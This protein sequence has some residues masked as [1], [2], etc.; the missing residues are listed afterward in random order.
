MTQNTDSPAQIDPNA[1]Q[2]DPR[3]P[4]FEDAAPV[5]RPFSGGRQAAPNP[6]AGIIAQIAL[7]TDDNG[8]AVAKAFTLSHED[9]D[10]VATD[11]NR[12][13]RQLSQA[14]RNNDPKVTV[15]STFTDANESVQLKPGLP[16]VTVY[17]TRVTFW[18][19]KPYASKKSDDVTPATPAE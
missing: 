19:V 12:V 1:V 15:R 7:K 8:D 13:T 10:A 6:Y 16:K 3:P 5:K 9:K 4:V 2:V 14:G 17:K 11:R 18:T